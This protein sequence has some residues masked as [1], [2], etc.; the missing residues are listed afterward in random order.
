[1]NGVVRKI[2]QGV[3]KYLKVTGQLNLLPEVVDELQKLTARLAPENIA[4]VSTANMLGATEKKLIKSQLE[5]L[6]GKKL[7]IQMHVDPNLL[8]GL[9]IRIADK[10]IDLSLDKDLEELSKKLK[11]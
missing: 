5:A 11:D 3:V 10:V 7:N 9:T 1:M 4:L 6:F 8:G 2:S